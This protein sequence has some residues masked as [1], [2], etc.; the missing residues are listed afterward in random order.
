M[1][2][3]LR[4]KILFAAFLS[5]IGSFLHATNVDFEVNNAAGQ[6]LSGATLYI[7]RFSTTGPD[8][9]VSQVITGLV[10]GETT[11][12][13]TDGF[14]YDI[15]ASSHN[16]GPSVRNQMNNPEHPRIE[17]SS[18]VGPVI[19]RLGESLTNRGTI[20]ANVTNGTANSVLFGNVRKISTGKD[21]AFAACE[22]DGTG[23]CTMVFDNIPAA[24][25]N[26]Y[27]ASVFDPA[28]NSGQG[29]G[30]GGPV[31]GALASAGN[32]NFPIN[33][34]GGLPPDR[35][36]NQGSG[37]GGGPQSSG[38]VS[39]EGVVHD[40]DFSSNTVPHVGIS[41][42]VKDNTGNFFD[43]FWSHGD[44]NGRFKFFGLE[45]GTT[46]YVRAMGGCRMNNDGCYD[47]SES[48]HFDYANSTAPTL[49]A[50]EPVNNAFLY[51]SSSTVLVVRVRLPKAPV[52][53]FQLPIYVKDESGR[54]LPGAFVNLWP[55]G[56]QW[57][58]DGG[59]PACDGPSFHA[60]VDV[61]SPAFANAN[62]Q[63]TTGYA[64]I[65]GLRAG[66]YFVQAFSQFGN[67]QSVSF[68]SGADRIWQWGPQG[69]GNGHRGCFAGSHDDLR[70]TIEANGMINIY[71]ASGTT[72]S[73]GMPNVSSV[74][75]Y[76]PV[77]KDAT[78]RVYGTLTFPHA[79]DLRTDPITILL[80]GNCGM[81]GCS[82]NFDIIGDDEAPNQSTYEYEIEVSSTGE[83][84][85]AEYYVEVNA[86]YWGVVRVGHD[87]ERVVFNSTDTVRKDF[88]FAPAGRVL[89][90]IYKPDGS[91]FIPGQQEGGGYISASVNA[92]GKSVDGWKYVQGAQDGS[93]TL[94]GLI[95]G[96][97]YLL[98]Q[99]FGGDSDFA[100][101]DERT[102]VVVTANADSYKDVRFVEGQFVAVDMDTNTVPALATH[103]EEHR[104]YT[105]EYWEAQR[106]PSGT[107][108]S[109][110]VLTKVLDEGFGQDSRFPIAPPSDNNGGPCGP[111]WPGGFCPK[112]VPS[113]TSFDIYMLRRGDL[114]P[115]S[116]TYMY[117]TIVDAKKNV[118]VD[119]AHT[120]AP[121]ISVFGQDVTPVHVDFTPTGLTP[122]VVITGTVTAQNIFRRADF[123]GLGGSFD[124][125]IKF[126]PLVALYDSEGD[127]VSAGFVTP[128]PNDVGEDAPGGA[129][130]DQAIAQNDFDGFMTLT[131]GMTWG[132]QIRG[133][134]PSQ[135][136]TLVATT[137]NYPPYTK[138][139]EL[140]ASGSTSTHH[141][142][143]DDEIGAGA[144]L[145]GVVT[146][147]NSTVIANASVLVKTEGLKRSLTTDTSG[148]YQTEGLTF[149]TYK[150]TVSADGYAPSKQ[151]V[152]IS[153]EAIIT[154]NF[155]LQLAP[156]SITGT[157][158]ELAFTSQGPIVR[159]VVG[160][161]VF[162]Y[163]DTFN[164]DNP[165]LPLALLKAQTDTEGVYT[166]NG[167]LDG[168]VYKI[169]VKADG[170]YIQSASTQ[171]TA[172]VVSGID[173]LLNQKPL[174]VQVYAR[175]NP[176][177]YEFSILNPNNFEEGQVWYGPTSDPKENDISDD[178][179]QLPDGSLIGTVPLSA[180]DPNEDYV[181]HIEAVPADG[182]PLVIKELTFGLNVEANS[183]QSID[184]LL[185]GDD[186][187]DEAGVPGNRAGA[188]A[189]GSGGS[190]DI[191]AGSTMQ[192]STANIP[193]INFTQQDPENLGSALDE[194]DGEFKGPIFDV[195]FSSVQFT[196]RPCQL[197]LEYDPESVDPS[198]L[199]DLVVMHYN[200]TSGEWE[201]VPGQVTI[202]PLT[203]VASILINPL[204]QIQS[205]L[206]FGQL[207]TQSRKMAA[208]ATKKQ[209]VINAQAASSGSGSFVVATV[210]TGAVS[211][212]TFKQYNFPNPF[213]L[214]QKTVT[215]RAGSSGVATSIRGTYIVVAPTGSADTQ[216]NIKIYNLAG[217]MV[218]EI[219][220]NVTGGVYNYFHWDGKNAAGSD[221]ASGVYFARVDAPGSDKKKPIKLVL[222]K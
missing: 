221:V 181:L 185:I 78:G 152:E 16:F 123:E 89:G 122:G 113:N 121:P 129:L 54:P 76:I 193:T 143:W 173:F 141:F 208:T 67:N 214:V 159:P 209:F 201:Q 146:S 101:P 95:P 117:L 177:N 125:F 171:A 172:G 100:A 119:E 102:T 99:T 63:A 1:L 103:E 80:R 23:A 43:R 176:P 190:M 13:L 210:S 132:Y 30:N 168:D 58:T 74:T 138:R 50:D 164:V 92:E 151:E 137:P 33:M 32:V 115:I 12:N 204:D 104:G 5:L 186:S 114:D 183:E 37:P 46:Y 178:F 179:E 165:L 88:R 85:G 156:G 47:G 19:V 160:A 194:I 82:G 150:V 211:D 93:F 195:G 22:T 222:V 21:L 38:Q 111:N 174:D 36:A 216:A 79:V 128:S 86:D 218:R 97:Y 207:S 167:V 145:N 49:G 57:H 45:V 199:D 81:N 220:G 25:G 213:N 55:D 71:N 205:Q 112:R 184:E 127:L 31:S 15:F 134:P 175:P 109:L 200:S 162:A 7:I 73:P 198:E 72:T 52:G 191:S 90:K 110:D 75:I 83:E 158:R 34:N 42:R 56:A 166:L 170:R 147:T 6:G 35:S 188:N 8:A 202:D 107:P 27:D 3:R 131:S 94:G 148:F 59:S 87:E 219:S 217:D 118:I 140:G 133:V 28:A 44:Q 39:V 105:G 41:L 60:V 77:L 66:N 17:P 182:G 135:T 130:I 48:T 11:V 180:L 18:V 116:D 120:S 187:E 136:Y 108:F 2:G 203:G 26:T 24:D 4:K 161:D 64:L 51:S 14:S 144:T 20:T 154:V 149:G 40:V 169:F 192:T 106:L 68:N 62:L 157:V 84:G 65:T 139:I 153:S 197:N 206:P 196:G 61:S 189:D 124:N 126:I 215:L 53:N 29:R 70:L 9:A 142:D 155:S 96:E 98:P 10:N 212:G 91:I 69:G 163:N